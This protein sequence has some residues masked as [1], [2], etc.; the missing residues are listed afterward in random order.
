M[1]VFN[2]IY[3]EK[4]KLL[5]QR[6]YILGKKAELRKEERQHVSKEMK[7]ACVFHVP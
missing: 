5:F 6:A 7:P 2:G 1:L 3:R 4:L